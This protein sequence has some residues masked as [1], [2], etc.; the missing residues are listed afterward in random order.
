[1]L[2]AEDHEAA[3]RSVTTTGHFVFV[4]VDVEG[5]PREVR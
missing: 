1:V 4:A 3:E 5:R 2:E